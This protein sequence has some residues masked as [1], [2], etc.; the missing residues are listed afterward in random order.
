MAKKRQVGSSLPPSKIPRRETTKS[1]DF[2]SIY[3][4]DI[5]LQT[6]SWDL[7][8]ILGEVGDVS[9]GDPAV[10][11]IKLIGELRMS[12]QL[13]KRLALILIEQL[14]RYEQ[15]FGEIPGPKE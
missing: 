5:Q 8:M 3:A 2:V 1:P 15:Q 6:S 12:P 10:A 9:E 7:R 13:A 11:Q 14:K 4:N